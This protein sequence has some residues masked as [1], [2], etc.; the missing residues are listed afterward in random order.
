MIGYVIERFS[1]LFV[2]PP[3]GAGCLSQPSF[4]LHIV[5]ASAV[6]LIGNARKGGQATHK[7]PGAMSF[8]ICS[9]GALG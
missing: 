7:L 2:S 5:I 9:K 1:F 8:F 6:L 4:W 3:F